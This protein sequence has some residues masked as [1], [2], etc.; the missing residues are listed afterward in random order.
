MQTKVHRMKKFNGRNVNTSNKSQPKFKDYTKVYIFF[1][2][3]S[4]CVGFKW[5]TGLR[6]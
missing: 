6:I 1:V 3:E 5:K 2:W 4:L